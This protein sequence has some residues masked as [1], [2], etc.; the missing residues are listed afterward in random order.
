MVH[1]SW[2]AGGRR[3]NSLGC[4]VTPPPSFHGSLQVAGALMAFKCLTRASTIPIGL[5]LGQKEDRGNLTR[6]GRQFLGQSELWSLQNTPG[7]G[8]GQSSSVA[9]PAA[10]LFT[11]GPKK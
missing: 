10:C 5:V 9:S 1:G 11:E 2:L 7:R 4:S 3:C 8:P 6:S